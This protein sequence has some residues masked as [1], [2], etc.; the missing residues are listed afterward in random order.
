MQCKTN[1]NNDKTY[2]NCLFGLCSVKLT[3]TKTR[4]IQTALWDCAV[5]SEV[6]VLAR[7][8]RIAGKDGKVETAS[9][10]TT[11]TLDKGLEAWDHLVP[12]GQYADHRKH[13]LTST[14]YHIEALSKGFTDCDFSSLAA[15]LLRS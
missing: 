7:I 5:L 11:H 4:L 10:A 3:L 6:A 14:S 1:S 12:G 2:P 9:H 8:A 13:L 15:V